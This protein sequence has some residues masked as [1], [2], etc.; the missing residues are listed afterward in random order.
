MGLVTSP[1]AIQRLKCVSRSSGE[2]EG[3]LTAGA[4]RGGPD[5]SS[6]RCEAE[7]FDCGAPRSRW[8]ATPGRRSRS[9]WQLLAWLEGRVGRVALGHQGG[10]ERPPN[11]ECWIVPPDSTA[12]RRAEQ[13]RDL[14]KNVGIRL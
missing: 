12:S 3:E 2:S 6:A 9:G 14:I 1:M 5:R 10:L 13:G 8:A 11:V 7:S 4:D